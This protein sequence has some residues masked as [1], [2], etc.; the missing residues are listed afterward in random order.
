VRGRGRQG[1]RGGRG[2]GFA[3]KAKDDGEIPILK[4]GQT[5]NFL[6]FRER[7]SEHA[8]KEFGKLGLII[9][10]GKY[11]EPPYPD[12]DDFGSFDPDI[13][14]T[15]VNKILYIEA[16]KAR[17]KEVR[18]MAAQRPNLY[19]TIMLKL[20]AESREEVKRDP[21]YEAFNKAKDPML[22]WKAITASHQVQSTSKV[23]AVV[24]LSARQQ[25]RDLKQGR[26]ETILAFKER[27]SEAARNLM[28]IGDVELAEPDVAMD[29]LAALDQ[30][31]YADFKV[32]LINDIAKGAM[33]PVGTLNAMYALASERLVVKRAGGG[34][35]GATFATKADTIEKRPKKKKTKTPGDKDKKSSEE[36]KTDKKT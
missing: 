14:L 12:E 20:S 9:E 25:Y 2:G 28:E 32:E 30:D 17:D 27:F 29:F 33:Q 23:E 24:K 5:T 3:D 21:G 4:Y 26:Y 19:A 1:G 31:R 13:D 16:M 34:T 22:L 6:K 35:P 7:L 11:Y 10:A 8:V 15:G 36:D 18:S